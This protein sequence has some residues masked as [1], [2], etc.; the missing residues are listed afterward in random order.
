M[1]P[2]TLILVLVAASRTMAQSVNPVYTDDSPAARDTLDRLPELIE[3][4][5]MAEGVRALQ[6]LL[7]E[8]PNRT[9]ASPTDAA[10]FHSVRDAVQD[11][12]LADAP[13]LARYREIQNPVARSLLETE[14]PELVEQAYLLTTAGYEAALTLAQDHLEHARF[15]AARITLEQLERHPDRGAGEP[16][17]PALLTLVARYLDRDEVWLRAARWATQA[18]LPAPEPSE[19]RLRERPPAA[20]AESRWPFDEINE[21]T[22][23]VAPKRPLW[24]SPLVPEDDVTPSNMPRIESPPNDVLW[25]IPSASETAI[26]TNDGIWISAW[27]RYTLELIWRIRPPTGADSMLNDDIS[28]ERMNPRGFGSRLEDP[29][30]V[31]VAG[32]VLVATTGQATNGGRDGDP[33][34]HGLDAATGRPVWSVFIQTLDPSLDQAV[35]VGAAQVDADTVVVAARKSVQGR[36]IISLALVGLDLYT[37]KLRWIRPVASAGALPYQRNAGGDGA[38]LDRGLVFRVDELGVVAGVEAM[39]GRPRWIRTMTP[40]QLGSRDSG[41]VYETN[42][43]IARDGI[44]YVRSADRLALY[45][46]D[47][48]TGE[49]LVARN[50]GPFGNPRY[51]VEVGDYLCAVTSD[52]ATFIR[53]DQFADGAPASTMRIQ[54]G[55]HQGIHGRAVA[56]GGKLLTPTDEGILGFDPADPSVPVNRVELDAPGNILPMGSALIVVDDLSI[57]SYLDWGVADTLL[58]RRMDENADD[59]APAITYAELAFRAGRAERIP[60]AAGRALNAIHRAPADP[61]NQRALVRLFES[62]RSMIEISQ[63]AWDDPSIDEPVIRDLDVMEKVVAKLMQS[64]ERPAQRATALLVEGRMRDAMFEPARA[65]ESYQAVLADA[66]LAEQRWNGA[67]RQSYAGQEA[68]KR[69]RNLVLRHGQAPYAPFETE[70]RRRADALPANATPASIEQVAARYP[71]SSIASKLWRRAAELHA[72]SGSSRAEL[73]CL[74]RAVLAS[75]VA[76]DAGIAP[77]PA[78][79]AEAVLAQ[80]DALVRRERYSGAAHALHRVT[81]THPGVDLALL[82]PARPSSLVM[83]EL[84]HELSGSTRPARVGETLGPDSQSFLGWTLMTPLLRPEAPPPGSD[85]VVLRRADR[86]AL[87]GDAGVDD[88]GEVGRLAEL[89]SRPVA[90]A[91][92]S[93]LEARPDAIFLTWNESRG[94]RIECIDA[95][96]GQTRWQ[97]R[98]FQDLFD[99]TPAFEQSISNPNRLLPMPSRANVPFTETLVA[100]HDGVLLVV[101]RTGRVVA[102]DQETGEILWTAHSPIT[103][104]F[105][106]DVADG[107]LVL[108]GNRIGPQGQAIQGSPSIQALEVRTGREIVMIPALAGETL[109]LRVASASRAIVHTGRSVTAYDLKSGEGV[110]TSNLPPFAE[111]LGA[112]VFDDDLYLLDASRVLWHA[113]SSTGRLTSAPLTDE[114]QL[115][116]SRHMDIL[117]LGDAIAVLSFNGAIMIEDGRVIGADGL[118]PVGGLVPPVA[119]ESHFVAL[120]IARRLDDELQPM[121]MLHVLSRESLRLQRTNVINGLWDNPDSMVAIDNHIVVSAG[122]M[123]FVFDLPA[124]KS[125]S[126][127]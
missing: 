83:S 105:E 36:R 72:Q 49:L 47:A 87:F 68:A 64:A 70:A 96:T 32:H 22:L 63:A 115:A 73:R 51:L 14:G 52:H 106:A 81:S 13:L 62:L 89:W 91:E 57:H 114:R 17:A 75:L 103:A 54:Q 90:D 122:Q 16:D 43:P 109:W 1:R 95:I 112:W 24:T 59:P 78:G 97:S 34:V 46:V 20:D 99:E 3:S 84:R 66:R 94:S 76:F 42:T 77:D 6:K 88:D 27:D 26:Y 10:L 21:T 18:G 28:D 107:V 45:A 53:F 125:A 82:D 31:S 124:E 11:R 120:E 35:P 56:M 127:R 126:S 119:T 55:E 4:G 108:G 123:T 15:E 102:F 50:A 23:P 121:H 33:R 39:T 5:N 85:H 79:P 100:K 117:R 67:E 7:N 44:V 110:W 58:T 38:V 19:A 118:D 69:I 101:E 48:E 12:L 30:T 2:L 86:V 74:Q 60:D 37:G 8:E 25:V 65:I 9:L 98:P 93:L 71:A 41:H 113:S 29:S 40:Q 92:P 111:A 61:E 116:A 80:I 104:L